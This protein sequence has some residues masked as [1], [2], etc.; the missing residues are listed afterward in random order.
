MEVRSDYAT[1][2]DALLHFSKLSHPIAE[3]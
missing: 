3:S 1:V 2:R